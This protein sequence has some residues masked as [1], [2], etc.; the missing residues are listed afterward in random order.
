MRAEVSAR[1]I[2]V[3][4][5]GEWVAATELQLAEREQNVTEHKSKR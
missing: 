4:E 5:R 2:E 3:D 1:L